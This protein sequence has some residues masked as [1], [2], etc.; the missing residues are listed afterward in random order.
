MKK[1]DI[2]ETINIVLNN[3]DINLRFIR[4]DEIEKDTNYGY[5]TQQHLNVLRDLI[6]MLYE[7]KEVLKNEI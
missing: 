6:K 1:E 2:Y 7:K 4:A 5:E 3:I